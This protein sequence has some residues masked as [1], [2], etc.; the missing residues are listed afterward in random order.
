MASMQEEQE[1]IKWTM[2][3]KEI[4]DVIIYDYRNKKKKIK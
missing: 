3:R 4:F 2:Q 1:T